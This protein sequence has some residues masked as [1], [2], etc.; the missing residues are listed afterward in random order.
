MNHQQERI[1]TR[2]VA[3]A[4]SICRAKELALDAERMEALLAKLRRFGWNSVQRRLLTPEQE[5]SFD[6]AMMESRRLP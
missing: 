2:D 6:N 3:E 1:L 5:V 4:A